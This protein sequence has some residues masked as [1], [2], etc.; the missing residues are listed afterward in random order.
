MH[1]MLIGTASGLWASD[2]A[3]P[4]AFDGRRVSALAPPI[5]HPWAVLDATALARLDQRNTSTEVARAEGYT[6]ECLANT[7]AGLFVGASE[8]RVL[9]LAADRLVEVPGFDEVDGR[10]RWFTPWG[11]PPDVRSIA[12]G[13]DGVLHVNVHVGGIISSADSGRTWTPAGIEIGADVHQIVTHP[14]QA[15]LLLAA[16]ARG[17]AT[18]EDGGSS[19]SFDDEGLHATYARAVAPAGD[20]LLLSMSRGPSGGEAAVYRRSLTNSM[21]FERCREGLPAWFDQNIDTHCLAALGDTAVFGTA[22]GTV[23]NSADA[24]ASW[25]ALMTGLPGVTCVLLGD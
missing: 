2:A 11:G 15:G 23:Y 7:P 17:L 5:D 18:S 13:A 19:W 1:R 10:D 16:C 6:I 21:P 22:D 12:S 8:A 3:G 14:A 20:M 25:E 24:G 4:I 9:T